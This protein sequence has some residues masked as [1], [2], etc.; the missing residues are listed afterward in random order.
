[1]NYIFKK[2]NFKDKMFLKNVIYFLKEH[3]KWFKD[4]FEKRIDYLIF[5]KKAK[6]F[7]GSLHFKIH[8]DELELGKI[9]C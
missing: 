8:S 7:I 9:Y 1:M 4:Y 2:K 6:E 5:E 3:L